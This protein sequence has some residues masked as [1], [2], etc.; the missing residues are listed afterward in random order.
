MR[1][2]GGEPQGLA[3]WPQANDSVARAHLESAAEDA[4]SLR[5][6]VHVF[7]LDVATR[8][9]DQQQVGGEAVDGVAARRQRA[10][11]R[12]SLPKKSL[13]LSSTT[14]K[15]GKS[16][17][18]IFQTASMPSSGYS[19]TSTFLMFSWASTAAG[20]PIEPR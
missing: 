17:T 15:A 4:Q 5:V 8:L 20:P 12:H 6:R 1:S 13:P 18:S 3:A 10:R 14:M 2:L 19:S 11:A 16:C 7:R 9:E